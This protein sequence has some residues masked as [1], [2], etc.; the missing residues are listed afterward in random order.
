MSAAQTARGGLSVSWRAGMI[1]PGAGWRTGGGK[2]EILE[3]IDDHPVN[4]L[5]ALARGPDWAP[6]GYERKRFYL[7]E[8]ASLCQKCRISP[9]FYQFAAI[10]IFGHG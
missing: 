4:A 9:V 3:E 5:L 8:Y 10:L 7:D 2:Y 1:P 6:M